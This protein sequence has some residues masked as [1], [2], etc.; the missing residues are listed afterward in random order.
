LTS[1]V[2]G[3]EWSASCPYRF[4]PGDTAP[5]AH[6]IRGWVSPRTGMDTVQLIEISYLCRESN[7]DGPDRIPSLHRLSY[8]G[9]F[10]KGTMNRKGRRRKRPSSNLRILSAIFAS[11]N[12]GKPRK[13]PFK[14]ASF[15]SEIRTW[16]LSDTKQECY[17]L[18]SLLCT[19]ASL[20]CVT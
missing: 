20:V 2:D 4:T 14:V 1:A 19:C 10:D 8:P 13:M 18:E 17:P 3:D 9:S 15:L 12:L 16:D 5:V 7:P 11:L 6:W